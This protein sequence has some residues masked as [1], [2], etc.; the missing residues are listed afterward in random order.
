M[1]NAII[2]QNGTKSALCTS[3]ADGIT[4]LRLYL[5]PSTHE[6]VVN[7]GTTGSDLSG[8]NASRD[9]NI[10]PVLMGTSSSDNATPVAPYINSAT[11]EL[12]IN[13]N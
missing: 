4:P 9:Q 11:N 10:E 6:I 8:D 3:N 13:S 2:D 7:D 1:T 5:D 12:L